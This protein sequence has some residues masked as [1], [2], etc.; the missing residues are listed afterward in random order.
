MTEKIK[1]LKNLFFKDHFGKT[2]IWP[3][4]EAEYLRGGASGQGCRKK[5][6]P[7]RSAGVEIF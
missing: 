1:W 3:L 2:L 4:I 5:Y 6:D 7:E